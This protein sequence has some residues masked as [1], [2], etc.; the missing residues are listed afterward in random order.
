MPFDIENLNL[1]YLCFNEYILD[2]AGES[3]R[4]AYNV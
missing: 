4:T 3:I 1:F 2:N